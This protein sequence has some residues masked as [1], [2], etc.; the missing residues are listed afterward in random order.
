MDHPC[1]TCLRWPE[2][3]GVDADNCPLCMAYAER[4]I[5]EA[6]DIALAAVLANEIA[7]PSLFQLAECLQRLG[8]TAAECTVMP[9]DNRRLHRRHK[10]VTE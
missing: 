6:E 7:L 1:D 3:N 5:R 2:C 10:E 4:T 8:F 9:G